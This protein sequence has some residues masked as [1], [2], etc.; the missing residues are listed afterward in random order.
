ML[1]R[2]F[3]AKTGPAD[4]LMASTGVCPRL[5]VAPPTNLPMTFRADAKICDFRGHCWGNPEVGISGSRQ[6]VMGGGVYWVPAA[7]FLTPPSRVLERVS[8]K[9]GVRKLP[10]CADRRAPAFESRPAHKSPDFGPTRKSAISGDIVGGI[11]K[12]GFRDL[13]RMSYGGG[14]WAPAARYLAS[15]SRVG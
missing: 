1:A 4:L 9:N 8:G 7:R 5:R 12:S 6:D 15:P 10:D 2:G 11:R 13:V 3:P 14:C